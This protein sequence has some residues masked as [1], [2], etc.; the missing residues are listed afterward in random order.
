MTNRYDIPARRPVKRRGGKTSA[1]NKRQIRRGKRMLIQ[2]CVSV[3]VICA[4]LIIKFA[5]PATSASIAEKLD[6]ILYGSVDYRSA[7]SV[8][9]KAVSGEMDARDALPEAWSYAFGIQKDVPKEDVIEVSATEQVGGGEPNSVMRK[10]PEKK[11]E[12]KP[13]TEPPAL[14]NA[15]TLQETGEKSADIAAFLRSQVAFADI[16]LPEDVTYDMPTIA[17]DCAA[18]VPGE[19]SSHFGYRMHPVEG[20]VMF[21]YG[22]DIA[23]A[24]GTDISAFAD[25]E[26]YAVGESTGYGKYMIVQHAD[27]V[28]TQYAH[29]SE[30]TA[31]QG[32][33]VKKGEII[34]KVGST[35]NATGSC[36]HF[37]ITV[38]GEYVNPEFYVTWS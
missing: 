7:L 18:P 16:E 26:V 31:K 36:L 15:E 32:S 11:I 4:A 34:A 35:G 22:T 17:L 1:V 28:K 24:E 38:D 23:A 21:H 25:G 37:E 20:K 13:E 30:I 19:V 5:L 9:G 2:L 12:T 3:S 8:L 6:G 14:E 27:G 10:E 33:A 29:C